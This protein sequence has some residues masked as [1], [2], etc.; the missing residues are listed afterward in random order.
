M[1]N[2]DKTIS[3]IEAFGDDGFYSGRGAGSVY[4]AVTEAVLCVLCG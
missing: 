3:P 4:E 1:I 2:R